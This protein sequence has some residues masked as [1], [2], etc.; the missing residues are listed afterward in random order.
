MILTDWGTLIH[1]KKIFIYFTVL[2]AIVIIIPALIVWLYPTAKDRDEGDRHFNEDNQEVVVP[3]YRTAQKQVEKVEIERYV[4]GVLSSEMPAEFE[5]EALKAQAIAARTYIVKQLLNQTDIQL[6]E[7]AIV[8]DT[9]QHQV[10]HNETELKKL[11]GK[12]FNWKYKRVMQAV[13]ETKG[14]IITYNDQPITASFF[15][16][17]NG[18]TE[19][20]E[21]YWNNP[22]PYLKSV[23]SPWDKHSPKYTARTTIPV[24]TVEEKL[25]VKLPNQ[26]EIGKVIK[27]TTGKKIAQIEIGGKTFTGREVREK[28]NLQSTDFTLTRDKD[29]VIVETKGYGHGVGMSQY[30]ANG[31]AKEGKTAEEIL[32]HYYQGTKIERIDHFEKELTKVGKN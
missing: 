18:F 28:L 19:N 27:R 29:N 17:S 9:I 22:I 16:T 12:D 7:E 14:K 32:Q 26:R 23:P 4:A 13:N 31:M 8:T 21:E 15:S 20:A 2:T 3:V 5:I 1:M 10:Y 11:W 24:R 30:G 25:N 6:P